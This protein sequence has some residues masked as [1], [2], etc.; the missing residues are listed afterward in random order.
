MGGGFHRLVR[1]NIYISCGV[2]D[3]RMDGWYGFMMSQNFQTE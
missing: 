3:G 2:C 1:W